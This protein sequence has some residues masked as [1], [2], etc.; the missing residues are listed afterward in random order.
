MPAIIRAAIFVARLA[1]GSHGPEQQTRAAGDAQGANAYC[2]D[3]V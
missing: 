2:T 1:V 3:Q